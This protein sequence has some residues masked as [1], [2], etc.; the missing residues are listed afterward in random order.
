[1]VLENSINYYHGPSHSYLYNN[2]LWFSFGSVG[3]SVDEWIFISLRF[4]DR[5]PDVQVKH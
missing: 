4:N 2:K 5:N 1:M 3:A